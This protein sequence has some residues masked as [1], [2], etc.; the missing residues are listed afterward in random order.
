MCYELYIYRMQWVTSALLDLKWNNVT[1]ICRFLKLTTINRPILKK[2]NL[3]EENMG[4]VNLGIGCYHMVQHVGS[5]LVLSNN[6]KVIIS[7]SIMFPFA[8]YVSACNL[9]PHISA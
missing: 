4:R 6:T 9:V 3:H 1:I 7:R 8:L 5:S 2:S